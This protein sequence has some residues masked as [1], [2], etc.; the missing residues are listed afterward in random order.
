MSL[1]TI[2]F[3]GTATALSAMTVLGPFDGDP[4]FESGPAAIRVFASSATN[5]GA[6]TI[7]LVL[8]KAGVRLATFT[9]TC[10]PTA[11]RT[12]A[13]GT[14]GG[15]VNT[16]VFAETQTSKH[17]LLGMLMGPSGMSPGL[18]GDDE[19]SCWMVGCSV[20]GAGDLTLNIATTSIA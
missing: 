2:T 16:V 6:S 10:T 7:E 20:R 3:T 11:Y 1:Q 8:V 4:T 9:A 14:G 13:A 19:G 18:S 17:D 12:D 15:Y 5:A